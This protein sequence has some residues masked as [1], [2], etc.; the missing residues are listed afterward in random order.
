MV[1]KNVGKKKVWVGIQV[2]AWVFVY[3][4]NKHVGC[5]MNKERTAM[6]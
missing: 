6:V 5:T 3:N 2:A 1:R 4:P